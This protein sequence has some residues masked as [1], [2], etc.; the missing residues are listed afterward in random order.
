LS[1]EAPVPVLRFTRLEEMPG[2][3]ANVAENAKAFSSNVTLITQEDK[4]IKTRYI[5]EKSKQ[6]IMRF[7]EEDKV[8]SRFDESIDLTNFDAIILSDY[9]KGFLENIN[10]SKFKTAQTVYVDTK[11]KDVSAYHNSIIKINQKE[12]DELKKSSV[13]KSSEILTTLGSKGAVYKD[14]LFRTNPVD[15]FDVSGAG[16][17]FLTAFSIFHT[18]TKND[19]ESI[20][21]ANKCAGLVVQKPGTFPLNKNMLTKDQ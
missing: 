18:I 17:T 19:N 3:A 5:D 13:H 21:F 16:D 1:P 14:V 8:T 9:C 4:I 6:H 2:M 15:I 11:R 7:D 12:C 10:T 20:N